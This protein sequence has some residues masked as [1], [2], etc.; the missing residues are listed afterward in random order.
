MRY[1]PA[2]RTS[3]GTRIGA[4]QRD[5]ARFN[6]WGGSLGGPII[7]DRLFAF[8]AYETQPEQLDYHEHRMV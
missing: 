4:P 3:N 5:T 8:F 2:V 1:Q 6:Q 7:K